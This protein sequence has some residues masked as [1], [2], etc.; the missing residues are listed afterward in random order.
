MP[1]VFFTLP[2]ERVFE[3]D[4]PLRP[5]APLLQPPVP[6]QPPPSPHP[7]PAQPGIPKDIYGGWEV[8]V[9][10]DFERFLKHHLGPG[11]LES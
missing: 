10:E 3:L 4:S 9:L 7:P 5:P 2:P 11:K 1:R 8:E 6:P